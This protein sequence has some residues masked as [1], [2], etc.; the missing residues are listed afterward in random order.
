MTY[1]GAKVPSSGLQ[2]SLHATRVRGALFR[3]G[4]LLGESWGEHVPRGECSQLR[5]KMIWKLLTL[6]AVLIGAEATTCESPNHS[7]VTFSTTD[8]F[9]HFSTTYIIEFNLQCANNVKDMAVYGIANGR[10]Y[11]AAVSEET[12]KHQISWQLEHDESAAQTFNIA[13]YDEDGLTAYRKAERSQDDI[14]RIK[15]LFTVQLKHPGVSKSSPVASETVVIAFALFALYIG[16]HF[17]KIGRVTVM[18]CTFARFIDFQDVNIIRDAN[19]YGQSREQVFAKSTVCHV[20]S[21]IHP[22]SCFKSECP[23]RRKKKYNISLPEND[24]K[25]RKAEEAVQKENK[26]TKPTTLFAKLKYYLKRYWYIAIP[27]HI[28]NCAV[29]FIVLYVAVKSG[30]DVVALLEKYHVPNYVVD[31]VKSIPPN[32][33]VAVVAFLLYKIATPLRYA[34]TLLL[35][36]LSFPVLRRLGIMTAKEV[37]YKMRLKYTNKLPMLLSVFAR[38]RVLDGQRPVMKRRW[39][40]EEKHI[41]IPETWKSGGDLTCLLNWPITKHMLST[42]QAI[43]LE[44][45]LDTASSFNRK[46]QTSNVSFEDL[47]PHANMRFACD[48]ICNAAKFLTNAGMEEVMSVQ[49]SLYSHVEFILS[50]SM[51]SNGKYLTVA[52]IACGGVGFVICQLIYTHVY[53]QKKIQARIREFSHYRDAFVVLSKHKKALDFLGLPLTVGEVDLTDRKRNYIDE[54]KSELRVPIC[55]ERDGGIMVI[56]AERDEEGKDFEAVQIELELDDAERNIVIYDNGSAHFV[57]VNGWKILNKVFR[58]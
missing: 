17:K 3:A 21:H 23:T 35:I 37:K 52:S 57:R 5:H 56:R 40:Y 6:V 28:A 51:H 43:L 38:G 15:P 12:S 47:S 41:I 36:Q 39:A 16:Y 54:R 29:W 33:G 55:G 44:N 10:V 22:E 20:D 9:F 18:H 1:R 49:R 31:R 26:E 25:L 27:I 46:R 11:Q 19:G 58:E 2:E 42:E 50:K 7:A 14:S 8:A 24:D 32:A 30:F 34:T 4:L 45:A 13:I 48:K 53:L